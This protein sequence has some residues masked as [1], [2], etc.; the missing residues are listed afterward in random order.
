[1]SDKVQ[2]FKVRGNVTVHEHQCELLLVRP[3]RLVYCTVQGSCGHLAVNLFRDIIGVVL[4]K[5]KILRPGHG[6]DTL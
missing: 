2:V 6:K 3:T 5:F 1:M 4:D